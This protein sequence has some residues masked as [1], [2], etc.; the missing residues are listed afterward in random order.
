MDRFAG[1]AGLPITLL[2]MIAFALL[3]VLV[4]LWIALPFALFGTKPLLRQLI[5]EQKR[6]NDLL[7]RR[8]PQFRR[9]E[10]SDMPPLVARRDD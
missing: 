6:T 1:L 2:V 7:D 10:P 3:V 5:A 8:L 4:V 9:P